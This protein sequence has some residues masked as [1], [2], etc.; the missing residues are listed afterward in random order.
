MSKNDF[1]EQNIDKNV[2]L[3]FL[4]GFITILFVVWSLKLF[5]M[6][7]KNGEQYRTQSKKISSQVTTIPAQRGE[8]FDRNANMPLVIN[9]ESFAV[10]I[11]PG[12]IP[13]NRYDSVVSKLAQFLGIKKTDID[14]KVPKYLRRSFSTIQIKTNVPF[15]VISNIAE[16]RTDLPG[17]SWESKPVRNY[18]DSGSLSHIIGYVGD[19]TK[20]EITQMYNQGY[21]KNSIVG[22]T[23]IEKQYDYLLQGTPGRE[24][25]TVDVRGRILSET[26]VI[27]PP[28]MGKNLVL[29][30]DS[31][32]QELVEKT[33]GE[34]VG[35]S[36]VLKPSTGEVLAMV[37]YPF[38][39]SNLFNRDN[40]AEEYEKLRNDPNNPFLNRAVMTAYPPASTFKVI[41][42]TAL[43][44]EKT[45]P[46]AKKIECNGSIYYGGHTYHCWEKW[47][48]GWLD[49]KEALAQ[50]CDVYFYTVGRDY[51]GIDKIAE[52][53]TKFG[54]GQS[55]RIDLPSQASGLVPT[56]VWK[57][58]SRHAKWVG[59]DTISVSIGQGD[60]TVTPLQL[61]DMVAMVNNK[62]T[63][64]KPH[65][66]KEVRDPVTNDVISETKPEVLF[67]ADEIEEEVWDNLQE[68]MHYTAT[69]GSAK[70]PM[71]L[72][73]TQVACKTGTG[74]VDKYKNSKEPH[75]HSWLVAYAPFDAP[76]EERI[77]I[78]TIVE[79]VNKWEWYAPYA[80]CIIFQGI[81]ENQTYE[82][83]YDALKMN[84]YLTSASSRRD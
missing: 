81:F 15:S 39:D 80:T 50:S 25:R 53:A 20:E 5:S 56:P 46:A 82:E 22:K 70:F 26:P 27:E 14:A 55:A 32:I 38:Y 9:T 84:R 44:Q 78:A 45:F 1:E 64:Y 3:V 68:Y 41:M 23:G 65:L 77:C 58:R 62:G 18:V 42:S 59:G 73:K 63:I 36:V 47:G 61:A 75:W 83:A 16:N 6:Q 17:V 37:S 76:P 79:A 48:Q 52:Y 43:L 72:L 54:L 8:I 12:E 60:L 74:E 34:R 28:Q 24:S 35:A 69:D 71:N 11:T 7:I 31:R 19:I 10:A 49:L 40:A 66:L 13:A 57:E 21:N 2:K 67:H 4:L 30:I 51:L 33:L 29:T